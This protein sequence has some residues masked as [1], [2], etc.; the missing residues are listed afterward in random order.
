MTGAALVG[1]CTMRTVVGGGNVSVLMVHCGG[2]A[3]TSDLS[4]AWWRGPEVKRC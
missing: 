1:A 3:C 2:P 4:S